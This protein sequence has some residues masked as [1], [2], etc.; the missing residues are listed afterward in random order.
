MKKTLRYLFISAITL[1]IGLAIVI[2]L[3]VNFVNP[4]DY[5]DPINQ[6][7][8]AYL[9]KPV[10][11]HGELSW[12]FLPNVGIVAHDITIGDSIG[13][14]AKLATAKIGV[15]LWPLLT[16]HLTLKTLQLDG[17]QLDITTGTGSLKPL[18]TAE[19]AVAPAALATNI[20]APLALLHIEKLQIQHASITLHHQLT[21]TTS[22][23]DHVQL[24]SH[25]ISTNTPIDFD[26]SLRYQ[27]DS[28]NL[29]QSDINWHGSFYLNTQQQSLS[30]NHCQLHASETLSNQQKITLQ[31]LG[32]FHYQLNDHSLSIPTLQGSMD[33]FQFKAQINAK[34]LEQNPDMQFTLDGN[35]SHLSTLLDKLDEHFTALKADAMQNVSLSTSGHLH[36]KQFE[37]STLRIACGTS[38]LTGHLAS[39][40]LSN[41]AFTADFNLDQIDL[42]DYLN[43]TDKTLIKQVNS[44][45]SFLLPTLNQPLALNGTLRFNDLIMDKLAI[46]QFSTRIAIKEQ[47]ISLNQSQANI[48]GII[49]YQDLLLTV[50]PAKATGHGTIDLTRKQLD[51]RLL[52]DAFNKK[53]PLW[54]SGSF[55]APRI[56]LD[57][58]QTIGSQLDKQKNKLI[59]HFAK[60]DKALDQKLHALIDHIDIHKLLSQ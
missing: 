58:Q 49:H 30:C 37:L 46:N 6:V 17:L 16:K 26:L 32:D 22:I 12:Q 14:H 59:K 53:M 47:V 50:P 54:I 31:A 44:H 25:S 55:N 19:I 11:I 42:A 36:D 21:Q 5:R 39:D 45:L 28:N 52:I 1:L 56:Q 27:A 15:Y 51:Y 23:I 40:D 4:N 33:D 35:T 38:L 57:T 2:M 34:W 24:L 29:S 10:I 20:L 3:I 7:A 13:D 8:T 43:N 18:A 60:D 41:R 9:K 48:T